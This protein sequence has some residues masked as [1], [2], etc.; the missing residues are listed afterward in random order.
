MPPRA[1]GQGLDPRAKPHR[2]FTD[3]PPLE[4]E[5]ALYRVL[6]KAQQ[7]R[8]GPIAERWIL[9]DHGLDRRDQMLLNLGSGLDASVIPTAP[10]QAKPTT[11]FTDGDLGTLGAQSLL[12][13]SDYLSSS[14][15]REANFFLARNS[16][17]ASP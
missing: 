7:C 12:N 5:D 8:H 2:T 10:W 16:S 15:S 4:L 1:R 6:V 9:L 13:I 14:P 3:L 11:D 17:M